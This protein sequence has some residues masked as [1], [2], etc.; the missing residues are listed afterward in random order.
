MRVCTRGTPYPHPPPTPHPRQSGHHHR[1]GKNV[2][3]TLGRSIFLAVRQNPRRPGGITKSIGKSGPLAHRYFPILRSASQPLRRM[4]NESR[5]NGHYSC[6]EREALESGVRIGGGHG[7]S[8]SL[9]TRFFS[10]VKPLRREFFGL[11]GPRGEKGYFLIFHLQSVY[12]LSKYTKN[13]CTRFANLLQ[14]RA[15]RTLSGPPSKY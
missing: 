14:F 2:N 5:R 15:S 7:L 13:V 1:Q 4:S 12:G 6:D 10:S 3:T 11:L 9:T 8:S